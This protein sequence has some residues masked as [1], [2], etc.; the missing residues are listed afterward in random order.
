MKIHPNADKNVLALLLI[1]VTPPKESID[2]SY[3]YFITSYNQDNADA[4]VRHRINSHCFEANSEYGY[5]TGDLIY[6]SDI[7]AG[8]FTL[9][10]IAPTPTELFQ[11]EILDLLYPCDRYEQT[12]STSAMILVVYPSNLPTLPQPLIKKPFMMWILRFKHLDQPKKRMLIPLNN[13]I[14]EPNRNIH[15]EAI[16]KELVFRYRAPFVRRLRLITNLVT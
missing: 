10:V 7:T 4:I 13:N 14:G 16:S 2:L 8:N 15:D 1:P 11:N 9:G 12:S 3:T 5:G 6:L